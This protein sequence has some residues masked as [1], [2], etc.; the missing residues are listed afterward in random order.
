VTRFSPIARQH[1]PFVVLAFSF[2]LTLAAASFLGR[3]ELRTDGDALRDPGAAEV[4]RDHEI[5]GR[6]GVENEILV[7]LDRGCPGCALEPKTLGL[8]ARL[9]REL[10]VLPGLR[11]GDVLSLVTEQGDRLL[12]NG[13]STF[14]TLLDPLPAGAAD[15]A[16]LRRDLDD[17]RLYDGLLV[18]NDRSA[19][20]IVIYVPPHLDRTRLYRQVETVLARH[21]DQRG[22]LSV[23]GAPVVEAMLGTQVLLDLGLPAAWL[24]VEPSVNDV[25]PGASAP[26]PAAGPAIFRWGQIPLALLVMTLIFLAAFR[27]PMA[28]IL[29]LLEVLGC[30]LF[31]FGIMGLTAFPVFLTTAILP[32]VLTAIGVS[33]EIHLF[34]AFRRRL[35]EMPEATTAEVAGAALA[36]VRPAIVRASL[37]ATCGCLSFVASPLE[38]VRSFGVFGALGVLYCL[39]FTLWTLPA[40]F[41]VI[42]RRWLDW[43]ERGTGRLALLLGRVVAGAFRAR[44]LVLAATFLLAI[45][46]AWASLHL[47]VQDSWLSGLD[48]YSGLRRATARVDQTFAGTHLLYLEV[49][50][51]EAGWQGRAPRQALAAA[52]PL[53]PGV[54]MPG[55]AGLPADLRGWWLE[56]EPWENASERRLLAHG[57]TPWPRAARLLGARQKE[58]GLELELDPGGPAPLPEGATATGAKDGEYRV[59]LQ[60]MPFLDPEVLASLCAFE[61]GLEAWPDDSLRRV[62]GPCEHLETMSY[63]EAGRDEKLRRVPDD[64]YRLRWLWARYADTRGPHRLREIVDK[65]YDRVLLTVFLRHANFRA[66][67]ELL[68]YAR[69]LEDRWLRPHRLALH[70]AGDV[71]TSQSLIESIVATQTASTFWG[72]IGIFAI[73]WLLTRSVRLSLLTMLPCLLALLASGAGMV[74]AGIPLGI[75][76][77]MISAMVLGVGVDGAIHW[78][79]THEA[80]AA[81]L[82]RAGLESVLAATAVCGPAIFYDGL[83]LALGFGVLAFSSVPANAVL[84]T[85]LALGVFTCVLAIFL[86]LPPL[87]V[88]RPGAGGVPSSNEEESARVSRT[89]PK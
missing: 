77:S 63:I 14:R 79:E 19:L 39:A 28:A 89:G 42:P 12:P 75:A 38:A 71:A 59:R 67:S 41:S 43:R 33:D 8:L 13:E 9:H 49:G 88:A 58:G 51:S 26:P 55:A 73:T 78:L 85:F 22:D 86:L 2:G 46:A 45:V 31:V 30:L 57:R 81:R 3:L 1:R 15:I 44:R 83:A 64:A 23:V 11:P 32:V 29:P 72:L 70:L 74:W 87:A 69:S 24:G 54:A 5:R 37:T 61:K 4:I 82:G 27:S 34:S 10:A 53:V 80:C 48:P 47:V 56:V 62:V 84:G 21:P 65:G 16:R 18:A 50:G 76:T 20:A 60:P 35:A 36:D 66:T 52:R 40:I 17:Y 25:D 6:F 68:A 7:V